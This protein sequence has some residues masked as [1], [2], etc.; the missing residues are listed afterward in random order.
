MMKF[1]LQDSPVRRIC[2][3][4]L[5]TL[6]AGSA[7]ADEEFSFLTNW[8]AQAE[9]GGYYQALATGLYRKLGLDVSIRMGG[10]Q[11]NSLQIMAAGQV[12][13]VLAASEM[14]IIQAR[15]N[16][17]P[18]AVVAAMFQKDPEVLIA[19]E[20]VKSFQ[21]MRGKTIL[22]SSLAYRGYWPWLKA[23]YGFTDEQARPYTFNIQPFVADASIIQQGYLTAEPFALQKAGVRANVFSFSDDGYPGYANTIACMDAT[24]QGRHKAVA[25]FVRATIEGWKSYLADPAPGNSLIKRD[26][27]AMTD[28]QLAYSVAK[29]K[30]GGLV[31]GGD[32]A[33]LGIG[34]IT[35]RRMKASYDFMVA[36]KLLD[37]AKIVLSQ[38][39]STE[40][41]R[42]LK[43][44][45]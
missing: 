42:D 23:K 11:V 25:D 34:T 29:L 30:E 44:L 36:A 43:I 13:C 4:F 21:D 19:H 3:F 12:D 22:I 33:A 9:H 1:R 10:P 39:Y 7:L 18:V 38:S 28:E 45:P 32:A 2:T 26:N 24:L 16:G 35:N 20:D 8:S 17:V 40:F 37:P 31:T 5:L 6:A 14:Q 41:V 15:Q 27:P